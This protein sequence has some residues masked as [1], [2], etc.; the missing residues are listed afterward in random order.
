MPAKAYLILHDGANVLVGAGC[1]VQATPAATRPAYRPGIHLPGGSIDNQDGVDNLWPFKAALREF[2]QETGINIRNPAWPALVPAAPVAP[3]DHTDAVAA[4]PA[5]GAALAG[6]HFNFNIGAIAIN[7]TCFRTNI[8]P[9][10][11]FFVV[12]QITGANLM[13][14]IAHRTV[15][16]PVARDTFDPPFNYV[17]AMPFAAAY[18]AFRICI[19]ETGW[20]EAGLQQAGNG[21]GGL[22]LIP[23]H[24]P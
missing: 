24:H 7:P 17:D 13:G 11:V 4:A 15:P 20:F 22:N 21:P 23:F 1:N 16:L 9:T 12:I 6:A 10:P 19:N 3:A 14:L 18:N 5:I 8:E 2:V